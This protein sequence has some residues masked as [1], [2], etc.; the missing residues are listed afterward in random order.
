MTFFVSKSN[1]KAAKA[2]WCKSQ[3]EKGSNDC[4]IGSSLLPTLPFLSDSFFHY[5]SLVY[6]WVC[7]CL[8]FLVS[9]L[10]NMCEEEENM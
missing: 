7:F 4:S 5:H 6:L 1:N 8:L 9:F 3:E 2:K 10:S